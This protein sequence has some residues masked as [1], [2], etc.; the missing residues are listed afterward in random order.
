MDATDLK[1]FLEAVTSIG[2]EKVDRLEFEARHVNLEARVGRLETE[3]ESRYTTLLNMVTTIKDSLAS[4]D[5]DKLNMIFV[6]VL[7][8]IGGGGLIGFLIAFHLLP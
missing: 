5:R 7:S 1:L 4:R 8:F 2:K 6:G 3:I